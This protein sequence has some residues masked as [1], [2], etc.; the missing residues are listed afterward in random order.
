MK[1][2]YLVQS[3][4]MY[5]PY[6]LEGLVFQQQIFKSGQPWHQQLF[7]V[8]TSTGLAKKSLH[9]ISASDVGCGASDLQLL[10][11]RGGYSE[12]DKPFTYAQRFFQGM[13]PY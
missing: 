3:D 5:L 13:A 9:S 8:C 6:F 1:I 2:F 7:S 11:A 12:C 10:E 4:L